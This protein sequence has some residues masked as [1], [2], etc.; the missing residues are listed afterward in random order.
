MWHTAHLSY[1]YV[2]AIETVRRILA[3]SCKVVYTLRNAQDVNTSNWR[4]HR[5]SS[6]RHMDWHPNRGDAEKSLR[7][8]ANS[9]RA[10]R[11]GSVGDELWTECIEIARKR[12][13]KERQQKHSR[14][15]LCLVRKCCRNGLI[16]LIILVLSV[17][18]FLYLC[19]PASFF[20]KRKLHSGY[21]L[22][23]LLF[24]RCYWL[25]I[26]GCILYLAWLGNVYWLCIHIYKL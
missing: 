21:I 20:L 7:E 23:I 5:V 3:L 18:I 22:L 25:W 19:K 26:I 4:W 17:G 14:E 6:C 2:A 8:L 15:L 13:L 9:L 1:I 16:G 12:L 24:L 10:Q 11:S